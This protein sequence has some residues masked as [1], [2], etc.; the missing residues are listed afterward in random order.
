GFA[1]FYRHVVS[2]KTYSEI[3]QQVYQLL[4]NWMLRRHRNKTLAWCKRKYIKRWGTRWQFTVSTVKSGKVKS[5]RLFQ[6]ADLPII[7][8]IKVRGKAHPYDPFYAE[9]FEQRR[10]RQWLRRKK[11]SRYLATPAIERMV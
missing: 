11:D 10:N 3:D 4:R 5:I 1:N 9:Y 2:K 7:R 6:V 8:H